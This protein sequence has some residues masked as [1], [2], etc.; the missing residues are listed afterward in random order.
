MGGPRLLA[1]WLGLD[2]LLPPFF[3]RFLSV[4]ARDGFPSALLVGLALASLAAASLRPELAAG[5][6]NPPR[7][8]AEEAALFEK[9]AIAADALVPAP[10]PPG[11]Q[12]TP[13]LAPGE[14]PSLRFLKK[15]AP[16]PSAAAAGAAAKPERL[17]NP[18]VRPPS[19]FEVEYRLDK[20]AEVSVA[21]V[22]PDGASLRDYR[23]AAAAPGAR[24]GLN[25]LSL[26]DG[27]D[28]QGR[29]AAPGP[30]RAVLVIREGERTQSRVIPLRKPAR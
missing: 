14:R 12:V 6:G 2:F 26:W 1:P 27:Q 29:E 5:E 23:I 22:G 21:I 16:K 10:P 25:R 28:S 8:S 20:D 3:Q 4:P 30:Y 15:P 13:S 7:G 18:L 24:Q 9:H 17:E 19:D 11:G